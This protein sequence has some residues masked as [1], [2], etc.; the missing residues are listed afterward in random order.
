MNI[1]GLFKNNETVLTDGAMGTYFSELTGVDHSACETYNIIKPELI[2]QI[3]NKYIS[4]GARIIRT[5]TF[6]ANTFSLG[7][8]REE[9]SRIIT[10]GYEIAAECANGNAVV[11]ANIGGIYD[12]RHTSE[13]IIKEYKFTA[14]TFISAGAK[15]F[16]F[17]TLPSLETV[18]PAID[19]ILSV[20]SDAE[21]ITS[22][23][24]LPDGRTR[25]GLS[26]PMLIKSIE[27]NKAKLT[28]VGFNCGCG[29]LQMFKHAVPFFSY[30]KQNTDLYTIVMPNAG[31]PSVENN[32]TVFTSTPAYFAEQ[33]A[34]FIPYGVS[35]IGGCCGT[36]PK[37]IK[38]LGKLLDKCEDSEKKSAD[39]NYPVHIKAPS[40]S[41][42]AEKKFIL[43]AELDPPNT[44]DLTKLIRSAEM[45]KESGVDIITVSDSPLG[46]A[47]MDS[48]ICSA[49]IK[50]DTGIDTLPHICCRDK[51]L[52]ALRSVLLGA[53]SEGIRS[54]LAVTGDHIAENDRGIVK[55]V[56]N[57]DSTHL[58]K[59]ISQ[60]NDDLFFD[61]PIIIGGAFDPAPEKA[62]FSLNRLD[63]KIKNGASFILTQPVFSEE[64][65][66]ITDMARDK[67]IKV[68][69]GIMP[70]VGYRN[71]NFMKNEVPGMNI[72]QELVD[73]F[74]INMTRDEAAETGIEIAVDIAMRMKPH[75][76][77]FYF[78]TPFNRAE[79]IS[80]I[81]K[82]LNI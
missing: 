21:I 69:I 67:G 72:P 3:H 9:I 70:M 26:V 77:G 1:K 40:A 42:L 73:R 60:M 14:D 15:T 44:S 8:P 16:I 13:E 34:R 4:A 57:V 11:C 68:L 7:L 19:Y 37:F 2:K 53:H 62:K 17:E 65:A 81:I 56:F 66:E 49:R 30:I 20:K 82:R 76:D 46:H 10:K 12:N 39:I 58:M 75:A 59:L 38:L 5:N 50:R 61:S 29:A 55:P 51:N 79:I 33:T 78:I 80:E 36:N 22:F 54:V 24:V 47:K 52:N 74:D 48:V 6:S 45:L 64:A 23:T 27:Q 32:R 28:M 43:A 63:K 31:Y 25:S 71:A 41:I 18:M 35:A